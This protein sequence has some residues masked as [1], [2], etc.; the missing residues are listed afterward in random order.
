M[1]DPIVLVEH[2]DRAGSQSLKRTICYVHSVLSVKI[3]A[4]E[5]RQRNHIVQA[6]GTAKTRHGKRQVSRNDQHNRIAHAGSLL[7]EHTCGLLASGR[8]QAG[9][10]IEHLALA[11]IILQRY[12]AKILAG[13]TEIRNTL[14][15][16]GQM[17]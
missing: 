2:D 3:P 15:F 13:E 1:Q 12:V 9:D 7:V 10:Y 16:F 11:G 4:T 6:F 5:S 8:I 17:T 14:A